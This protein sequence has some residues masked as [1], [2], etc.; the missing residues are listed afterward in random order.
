MFIRVLRVLLLVTTSA[1]VQLISEK[2]R[3]QNDPQSMDSNN[4]NPWCST[5]QLK[6]VVAR[7]E[8]AK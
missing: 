5:A 4:I 8:K 7:E 3:L 2:T 6:H 1:Q